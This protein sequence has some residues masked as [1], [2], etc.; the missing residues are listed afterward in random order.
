MSE[1]AF[2]HGKICYIIM[3]SNDPQGSARF[4]CDVFGWNTRAH[5]DGTHAFDDSVGQV[6]GMW[7]TDREAVEHPGAEVHIMVRDAA[8][9]EHDIV[10]NGGSHIWRSGPED[11]EVYGTFRDPSGN[12]FGYYE[13][14]G[15]DT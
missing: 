1:P 2:A 10:A 14:S 6:S 12:L 8:E 3:P 13:Q 15:L 5:D 7:V 11:H 4:Y 9:T